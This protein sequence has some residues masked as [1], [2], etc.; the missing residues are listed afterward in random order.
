MTI[1]LDPSGY[2]ALI[3]LE[4]AAAYLRPVHEG[5]SDVSNSGAP[6]LNPL[7]WREAYEPNKREER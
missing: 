4:E 1:E 6:S 3:A 2:E 7:G 5:L